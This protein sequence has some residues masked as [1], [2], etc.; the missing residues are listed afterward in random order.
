MC[1][2]DWIFKQ[3]SMGVTLDQYTATGPFPS[4][5]PLRIFPLALLNLGLC[6]QFELENRQR[7][8]SNTDKNSRYSRPWITVN[9]EETA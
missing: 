2:A 9:Q 1:E 8:S 5:L 7:S 3:L 6:D 4:L